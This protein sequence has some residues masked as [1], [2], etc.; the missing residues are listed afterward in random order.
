MLGPY[1]LVP[2][3]EQSRDAHSALRRCRVGAGIVHHGWHEEYIGYDDWDEQVVRV[4]R[5]DRRASWR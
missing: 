3:Q 1:E 4:Q 5:V 2:G